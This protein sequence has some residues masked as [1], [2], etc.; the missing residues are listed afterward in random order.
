M[1]F[2]IGKLL[3]GM[4]RNAYIFSKISHDTFRPTPSFFWD[5]IDIQESELKSANL[6]DITVIWSYQ[7]REC[8]SN[9]SVWASPHK[10][11]IHIIFC[12]WGL[13]QH[14]STCTFGP[15]PNMKP[16]LWENGSEVEIV[17]L[18]ITSFSS[19]IRPFPFQIFSCFSVFALFLQYFSFPLA[20]KFE[21]RLYRISFGW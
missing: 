3:R 17:K 12:L 7:A 4:L 21:F 6:D 10:L 18:E 20:C 16:K 9:I 14:G 2:R 13:T 5:E 15:V 11:E 1:V 19:R 8:F